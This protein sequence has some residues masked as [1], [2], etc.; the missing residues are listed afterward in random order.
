M[1]IRPIRGRHNV[2]TEII[3]SF[4]F[5]VPCFSVGLKCYTCLSFNSWKE[6]EMSL[7]I[8]DC[9][10]P[11]NEVCV[12]EQLVEHD[13]N[14]QDGTKNTFSKFCAMAEACKDAHCKE[15]GKACDPRCCH[16]D[17][18]N[19]AV[20]IRPSP[21]TFVFCL[22]LLTFAMMF[23]WWKYA[24]IFIRGHYLFPEANSFPRATIS[25]RKKILD[26]L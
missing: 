26:G 5:A 13:D 23:K 14:T 18:C 24:R 12:K 15:V 25:K 9:P 7:K 2:R 22:L 17:L 20:T 11:D 21:G 10:A 3:F 6:C 1:L 16:T 4:Y 8:T 19:M